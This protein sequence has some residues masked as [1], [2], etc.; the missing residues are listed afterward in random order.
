V[1]AAG[2]TDPAPRL[3]VTRGDP[4]PEEVAALL[5]VLSAPPAPG[6]GV[7][8]ADVSGWA[9]RSRDV[10]GPLVP[11]PGAWQASARQR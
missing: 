5:A 4:T 1:S 9:D 10:R 8:E 3:A 7:P 11:G 2:P 6:A